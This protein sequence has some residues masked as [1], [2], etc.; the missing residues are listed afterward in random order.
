MATYAGDISSCTKT[1][2]A[3][4]GHASQSLIPKL[5]Q[6]LLLFYEPT[7]KITNDCL[8]N[9]W[10]SNNL[11]ANE[12]IDIRKAN[13]DGYVDF[14]IPLIYKLLRNL[15]LISPPTRGWNPE[16]GPELTETT[17]GDDL[18]RFRISRNDIFH[19]GNTN[20]SDRKLTEYFTQFKDI[21]QRL[22]LVLN[23]ETNELVFEFQ[24]LETC[25]MDG[26]SEQILANLAKKEKE[27]TLPNEISGKVVIINE[28][29][30][31]IIFT[32]VSIF[33]E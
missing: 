29:Y 17:I 28:C 20:V 9:S 12:W 6:Q 30:R 22:E 23:K 11:N 27:Y 19:R 8:N 18:E 4:L 10:L 1:N 21:A 14:D 15:N 3:R 31:W 25:C 2:Y 26:V 33:I 24:N 13:T 5:L 32:L 16:R 7:N